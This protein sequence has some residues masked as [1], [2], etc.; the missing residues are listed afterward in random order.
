MGKVNMVTTAYNWNTL[1]V[2]LGQTGLSVARYLASR[3]IA[4]A[5]VD[6]RAN[7]PG[8]DELLAQFPHVPYAFGAFG[9]VGDWFTQAATLVVSPG[10][11]VATPEIRVAGERGAAIIGD[12]ELFVREA[13]APVIAITGS[14]GKSSVTTLVDLMAKTA[15]MK[16]YAGGN[17]GYAALDLL[18]QPVPNLYVMELSSFQLETTQSLQAV[19]AV[20]L[21]VSEDHLDR[22]DSY[23]DYAATKAVIYRN[24]RCA[25]VNRDDP[26]VMA[27]ISGVSFGLDVPA[28]GHYGV[29][30]HDGKQWL[31]KGETLLLAADAMKLPGA[32][33]VANALAALALGEAAGIP[34]AGM[35]TALREFTGLAH[36][37]QWVRE[38]QGVNWYNDSKGTNVG[39]TLAALAGLPSKTVLIAGGQGKG[40]DFAP[41]RPVAAEKARAVILIG[42]DR[43]KIAAVLEGYVTYWLAHS[44][45]NA[46]EL[47]AEL[48]LPGDNVLLSPAC[49]SFD[50]FKGYGHRGDVF[51]EAVRGLS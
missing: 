11:A 38:R 35:L 12:I 41:L 42:E 8:K 26:L 18:V 22:Y 36:R 23:A 37:T 33:N 21:N 16:S 32:H 3:N 49:A 5:V 7:P 51:S 44:M 30:E 40:A 14:N 1:V 27:M 10:I 9:D 15:G 29:R 4:F 48:A 31:A 50:M 39:A 25:V 13:K 45:E 6:S 34:L 24:C 46:V 43:D 2:G 17:L 20:V 19:A 47:A 28:A